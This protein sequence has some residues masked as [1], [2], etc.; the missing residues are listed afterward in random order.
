MS[1]KTFEQELAEFRQ[2]IADYDKADFLGSLVRCAKEG[3]DVLGKLTKINSDPEALRQFEVTLS[4]G[5][6]NL[7]NRALANKPLYRRAV[8]TA[9]TF[10]SATLVQEAAKY[11]G[12]SDAFIAEHVMPFFTEG[13]KFCHDGRIAFGG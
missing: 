3:I 1:E 8:L 5:L 2:S 6:T 13:E 10:G 9:I 12:R 11:I 4:D 7:V